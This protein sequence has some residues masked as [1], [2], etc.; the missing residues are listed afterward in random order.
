MPKMNTI[1]MIEA[2]D[3]TRAEILHPALR[4]AL[5][6]RAHPVAI[7]AGSGE[8]RSRRA[9]GRPR[10]GRGSARRCRPAPHPRIPVEGW[11]RRARTAREACGTA[12]AISLTCA[13]IDVE[14][15]GDAGR[16]HGAFAVAGFGRRRRLP[17]SPCAASQAF[18]SG[19]ESSSSRRSI[20]SVRRRRLR[21]RIGHAGDQSGNQKYNDD[22]AA[23]RSNKRTIS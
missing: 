23:K 22:R 6:H 9:R 21:K 4:R 2:V 18:T 20:L 19:S 1:V 7:A 5:R 16:R 14:P 15:R 11:S 12:A 3:Q 17:F 10:P 13:R 8:T